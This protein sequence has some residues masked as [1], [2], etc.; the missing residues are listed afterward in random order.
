MSIFDQ[1]EARRRVTCPSTLRLHRLAFE[2]PSADDRR[3]LETCSACRAA[4]EALRAERERFL[5]THPSDAFIGQLAADQVSIPRPQRRWV[6]GSA[7]AMAAA[8]VV[9]IGLRLEAPKM[10]LKGPGL[11][12][13][14]FVGGDGG[15]GR[16]YRRS[17]ALKPGQLL[18]IAVRTETPGYLAVLNLDDRGRVTPYISGEG[19]RPLSVSA[20]TG[21]SP[22]PQA[23]RLDAFVGRELVVLA[24]SPNPFTVQQVRRLLLESF[25]E[26][27]G[28]LE[29]VAASAT[30]HDA[31]E[32]RTMP[33]RKVGS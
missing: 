6:L 28:D 19:D 24:F 15:P 25:A 16:R 30:L 9:V 8:A 26:T 11:Q 20:S 13:S 7:L 1:F 14:V 29:A 23:I 31:F 32:V 27:G 10:R 4:V 21:L 3:H 18:Q 12:W 5:Q 17:E 22:L 33:I 2:R